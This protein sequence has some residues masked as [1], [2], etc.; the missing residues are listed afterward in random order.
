MMNWMSSI[1]GGAWHGNS[2]GESSL[3]FK[4]SVWSNLAKFNGQVYRSLLCTVLSD[5]SSYIFDV[6]EMTFILSLA[7][8]RIAVNNINCVCWLLYSYHP[9]NASRNYRI[10]WTADTLSYLMTACLCTWGCHSLTAT[11]VGDKN[12]STWARWVSC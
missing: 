4:S 7:Y 6:R 11:R 3:V 2:D 12:T 8:Y 1:P 9:I 10:H 5:N